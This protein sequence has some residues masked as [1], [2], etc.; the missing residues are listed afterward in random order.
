LLLNKLNPK[1]SFKIDTQTILL[2]SVNCYVHV[3]LITVLDN[4]YVSVHPARL[5]QECHNLKCGIF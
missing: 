2:P 4:L 5:R 1:N 3:F